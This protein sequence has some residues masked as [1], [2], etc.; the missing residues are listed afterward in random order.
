[1]LRL[2]RPHVN[3]AT[4]ARGVAFHHATDEVFHE[5]VGFQQL[6]REAFAWLSE[7]GMPRGPARAVAHIGIEMLLDEVMAREPG[8]QDAYRAALTV[9]LASLLHFADAA[10]VER[11]TRLQRTLF[12]RAAL[13]V[14][15]SPELL[16]ERIAR[17]LAGRP[18]LATD[19][20]GERLLATWAT[21]TRPRVEAEAPGVLATLRG[22]LASFDGAE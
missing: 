16:A 20:Q 4:V 12:E 21:W 18:R 7:R 5:L 8:A 1:M 6:S 11:L 9:P 17:T 13:L 14:A 3:D 19:A 22:K 2:R 10:D 15:P